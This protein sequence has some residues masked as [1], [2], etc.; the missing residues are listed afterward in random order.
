MEIEKIEP[1]YGMA[2]KFLWAM[3]WRQFVLA[4]IVIGIGVGVSFILPSLNNTAVISVLIV[5]STTLI[6]TYL[7]LIPVYATYKTLQIKFN[8]FTIILLEQLSDGKEKIA[9]PNWKLS[10]KFWWAFAW[11][12]TLVAMVLGALISFPIGIYIEIS[13]S[14]LVSSNL[15]IICNIIGVIVSIPVSIIVTLQGSAYFW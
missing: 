14:K 3:V 11:R 12:A 9:K 10:L 8:D 2:I 13:K 5:S 4:L 7:V 1:T 6:P 15:G